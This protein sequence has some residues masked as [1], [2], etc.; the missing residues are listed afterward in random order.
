M[1]YPKRRSHVPAETRLNKSTVARAVAHGSAY[2]RDRGELQLSSIVQGNE[3]AAPHRHCK[4][5]VASPVAPV[6]ARLSAGV[7][8]ERELGPRL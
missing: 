7:Q 5:L 4:W 3:A 8:V 1:S 6:I 2:K